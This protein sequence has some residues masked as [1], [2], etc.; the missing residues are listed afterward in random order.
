MKYSYECCICITYHMT[1]L[2]HTMQLLF[3]SIV[4]KAVCIIWHHKRHDFQNVHK[5][6]SKKVIGLIEKG[7]IS[8]VSM[9]NMKSIFDGTKQRLN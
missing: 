1:A 3:F 6:K 9:P 8:R 5:F 4:F 2:S 7:I